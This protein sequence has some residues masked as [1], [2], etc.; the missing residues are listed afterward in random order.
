MTST[1]AAEH[2]TPTHDRLGRCVTRI[3][4]RCLPPRDGH[5]RSQDGATRAAGGAVTTTSVKAK[6]PAVA[7]DR[8]APTPR[9]PVARQCPKTGPNTVDTAASAGHALRRWRGRTGPRRTPVHFFRSLYTPAV[10]GS[11]P[12]APTKVIAG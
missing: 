4:Q 10:G 9:S 5:Q 2:V 7:A 3:P 1:E 8:V 12:S 6:P 11:I